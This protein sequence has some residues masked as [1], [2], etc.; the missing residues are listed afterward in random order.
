MNQQKEN[1]SLV[2]VFNPGSRV[3]DIILT[4]DD[5]E[6]GVKLSDLTL[7]DGT[8]YYLKCFP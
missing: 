7:V 2:E 6:K 4:I 1:N 3:Q 5:I 8:F